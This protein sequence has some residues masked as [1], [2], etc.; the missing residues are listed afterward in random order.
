VDR[1]IEQMSFETLPE[2][3]LATAAED[4]SQTFIVIQ[5]KK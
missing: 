3:A 1:L 2:A 5:A 4:S